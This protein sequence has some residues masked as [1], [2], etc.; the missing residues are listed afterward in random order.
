M[1]ILY[2]FNLMI[3]VLDGA[4]VS[5]MPI[6]LKKIFTRASAF[7]VFAVLTAQHWY[8]Q[9]TQIRNAHLRT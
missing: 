9:I 4:D 6:L 7:S 3:P 5:I 8:Y 2:L 1:G